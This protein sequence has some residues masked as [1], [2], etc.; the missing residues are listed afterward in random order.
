[1]SHL[2]KEMLNESIKEPNEKQKNTYSKEI[3]KHLYGRKPQRV[4]NNFIEQY[5]KLTQEK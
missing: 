3:N 2:T 4:K 5:I 1:M